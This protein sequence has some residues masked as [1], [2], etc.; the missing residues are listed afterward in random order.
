MAGSARPHARV[1]GKRPR[2]RQHRRN[3]RESGD[4]SWASVG[5]SAGMA[6]QPSS[7]THATARRNYIFADPPAPG[8]ASTSR[9]LS[10]LAAS[11]RTV[12][13]HPKPSLPGRRAERRG[14]PP[15]G[16][17]CPATSAWFVR[18][19]APPRRFPKH[20]VSPESL[21][22]REPEIPA[23]QGVALDQ[24]A[25]PHRLPTRLPLTRP[26]AEA[27]ARQPGGRTRRNVGARF[28]ERV[29]RTIAD[30]PDPRRPVHPFGHQCRIIRAQRTQPASPPFCAA[31]GE[32]PPSC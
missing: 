17:L 26:H 30:E 1:A 18:R 28:G 3:G 21:Q 15:R 23:R 13:S 27:A 8:P 25:N 24:S 6:A 12:P 16:R 20:C 19:P 14:R 31:A 2:P 4:D 7:Q 10:R 29:H 22:Q 32:N 5:A 11:R 9:R